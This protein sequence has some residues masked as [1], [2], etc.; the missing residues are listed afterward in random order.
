MRIVP[1][2]R[3]VYGMQLPVQAQSTMFAAEWEGRAGPEELLRLARKADESGFFYVAVCDHVAVPRALAPA[4]STVWYDTIATLGMLAGVTDRVRLMSHVWVLPYRHPLVSAKAFCTLDH[5]SGGRV[6][7]GVGAGHAAG[8]FAALGIEYRSRGALLD[9]AIDCLKL[10]LIEEFPDFEGPTWSVHDVGI[11]PR[12]V[13]RPRPP[14]WVGGSSPAALRRA[15]ERGDGW[16]P[17]GT[18]RADMPAQISTVLEHRR[19]AGVVEP[20]ELGTITEFLYCGTPAWDVGNGVV[21]G[22]PEAIAAS[23]REFAE[24]GV[25][26]LQVRFPSRSC[27]ELEDQM[28]SFGTEVAP[29]L[30]QR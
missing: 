9:E 19:R 21:S 22:P 12:P 26:H 7:I 15:A 14:I 5:L 27:E 17:Q 8:E 16:L 20:I 11:R 13:Q 24:M 25:T 3:L 28:E 18:S 6:I 2:N 30:D 4:M 29:L 1:E 23:L 10:A